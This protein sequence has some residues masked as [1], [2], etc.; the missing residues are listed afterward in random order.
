MIRVYH[1]EEFG[2]DKSDFVLVAEVDTDDLE[3]AYVWTQN[4]QGS[5][6]RG[7]EDNLDY[8]PQVKVMAPLP[9]YNGRVYGLRS[10]S[11]EDMMEFNGE[12]FAVDAIGFTSCKGI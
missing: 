9:V 2:N 6:S 5:W 1:R 8:H 12:W 3:K 4:I 7:P 11:I 10:T